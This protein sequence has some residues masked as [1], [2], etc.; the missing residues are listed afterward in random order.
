MY[1]DIDEYTMLIDTHNYVNFLK[2]KVLSKLKRIYIILRSNKLW[3]A[4]VLKSW[5]FNKKK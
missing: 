1:V 3:Y 5:H 2:F 4:I